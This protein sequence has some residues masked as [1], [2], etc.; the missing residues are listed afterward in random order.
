MRAKERPFTFLAYED[1]LV[2]PFFQRAYVWD[3]EN[4]NRLLLQLQDVDNNHF[5]GPIILKQAEIISGEPRQLLVIDGQQRLTTLSILLRVLYNNVTAHKKLPPGTEDK[6]NRCLFYRGP[7]GDLQLKIKHSKVDRHHYQAVIED[8]N[9]ELAKGENRNNPS[10]ILQCYWYYNKKISDL[11][12]EDSEK[13]LLSLLDPRKQLMV[14]IGLNSEDDEQVIFEGMNNWGKRLSTA[15]TVKHFIFQKAFNSQMDEE[16]VVQLF[17]DKWEKVFSYD[18]QATAYWT[19]VLYN[20]GTLA[21]DR[22]EYFLE[23]VAII[24]GIKLI[25]KTN[26]TLRNYLKGYKAYIEKLDDISLRQFIEEIYD[27]GTIRRIQMSAPTYD[28]I[29]TFNDY[30]NR[31]RQILEAIKGRKIATGYEPYEMHIRLKHKNDKKELMAALQRFE[32]FII[33]NFI[34][35]KNME[36]S[37]AEAKNKAFINDETGKDVILAETPDNNTLRERLLNLHSYHKEEHEFIKIIKLILFWV[38]LHRRSVDSN[39]FDFDA[40]KISHHTISA[41]HIMPKYWKEH[42]GDVTILDEEGKEYASEGSARTF[43]KRRINSIGNITLYKTKLNPLLSNLS[44]EEKIYGNEADGMVGMKH[45]DLSITKTDIVEPF[46]KGELTVWNEAE[47]LKRS[48]K[49]IDEVLDMWPK[50]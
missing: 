20:I 4:W 39:N 37:V 48:N 14:I 31:L 41:E 35:G 9:G 26:A 47:I 18:D 38:E 13:L 30:E 19:E 6:F 23:D 8:N 22:L 33:R 40:L 24:K 34:C 50:K 36:K 44:F 28:H 46:E 29:Y 49:I 11:S 12:L 5:I 42:W 27:Y 7:F 21:R 16:E 17:T 32:T 45:S 15:D 10:K 2:I 43:R 25:S 3:D 1:L